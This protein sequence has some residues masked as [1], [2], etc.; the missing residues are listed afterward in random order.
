MNPF[1]LR[2]QDASSTEWLSVL[3]RS[4]SERVIDEIEFPTFPS[5]ETQIQIQGVPDDIAIWGA[6]RFTKK[7]SIYRP[8][9]RTYDWRKREARAGRRGGSGGSDAPRLR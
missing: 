5:A 9:Q 3:R 1:M 6:H 8:G 7:D 2:W 4:V